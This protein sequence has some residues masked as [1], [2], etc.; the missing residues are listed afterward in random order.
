MT[1][2]RRTL[3]ALGVLVSLAG[4]S[5]G[6]ADDDNADSEGS[7]QASAAADGLFREWY[8]DPDTVA[9][10]E[11]VD[12]HS[13]A[14]DSALGAQD[15]SALASATSAA[16]DGYDELAT[17]GTPFSGQLATIAKAAWAACSSAYRSFSAEAEEGDLQAMLELE[18]PLRACKSD[19]AQFVAALRV[20]DATHDDG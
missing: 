18:Q 16:A 15:L 1:R 3:L 11:R 2:L 17:G 14:A 12:R 8:S 19:V 4:C 6:D 9:I 10:Q 20:Y 7:T 13:E 5:S